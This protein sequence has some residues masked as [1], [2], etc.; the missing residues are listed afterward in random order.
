MSR[1]SWTILYSSLRNS[2]GQELH[3]LPNMG[4][5]EVVLEMLR[6]VLGAVWMTGDLE[7][8]NCAIQVHISKL[9]HNEMLH[10]MTGQPC[11]SF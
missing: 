3:G 4:N 6:G 7:Q 2:G 5:V 10:Q 1:T 11:C 9:S 8:G